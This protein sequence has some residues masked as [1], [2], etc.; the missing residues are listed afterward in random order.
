[1]LF[2]GPPIVSDQTVVLKGNELLLS[3]LFYSV[4]HPENPMWYAAGNVLPIGKKY[5]SS[6]FPTK[7]MLRLY[8]EIVDVDGY[9][10]TLFIEDVKSIDDGTYTCTI[11]NP[12]GSLNVDIDTRET[13]QSKTGID[14]YMLSGCELIDTDNINLP[15]QNM[16]F[17][18][19]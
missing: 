19:G 15:S 18:G 5:R 3:S 10:T 9:I 4:P 14:K 13:T 6:T 7:I 8:N 17:T 12:F 16:N 11:R 1:M 2:V